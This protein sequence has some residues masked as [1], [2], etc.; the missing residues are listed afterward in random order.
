M[1]SL[2]SEEEEETGRNLLSF[3]FFPLHNKHV[4]I[5]L[6]HTHT[7]ILAVVC[8][9]IKLTFLGYPC[10]HCFHTDH[11][12]SD[13][14]FLFLSLLLPFSMIPASTLN[15]SNILDVLFTLLSPLSLSLSL[16]MS[17]LNVQVLPPSTTLFTPKDYR[18][19]TIIIERQ[20]RR[21]AVSNI[22]IHSI[23]T[24]GYEYRS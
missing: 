24:Y 20:N 16:A 4:H 6:H 12:R 8:L 23:C 9:Y 11:T 13:R 19:Y 2:I 21:D 22:D 15:C 1:V 10:I 5:R 3:F 17:K 18:T 7:H 14:H